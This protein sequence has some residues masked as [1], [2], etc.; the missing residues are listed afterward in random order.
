MKY[1]ITYLHLI[2]IKISNHKTICIAHIRSTL[3]EISS[4]F[5]SIY[6]N[7]IKPSEIQSRPSVKLDNEKFKNINNILKNL[8]H[9][10]NNF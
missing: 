3:E 6:I 5:D 4:L 2:A 9:L 10:Q 1:Q 7:D 8:I